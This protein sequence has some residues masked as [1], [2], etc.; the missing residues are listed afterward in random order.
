[1][2][3]RFKGFYL[4][5]FIL[6]GLLLISGCTPKQE[7]EN[8]ENQANEAS[9]AVEE[10]G[11]KVLRVA[12][13]ADAT[14]LDPHFNS[15]ASDLSITQPIFNGL[16]RFKPGSVSSDEIEGDL[17]ESWESNAEGT[18]WTFKLR[19]GVQ[20]HKGYGELTSEDVKWTFERILDP[21]IGSRFNSE[22]A[23]IYKVEAPAKYT[24]V[25]HLKH[26]DSAFLQR[27]LIDGS[28]GA[29]VKK[30]AIEEAG[31]N[32]ITLPV[33]TGP[34]MLEEYK[35]GQGVT[36]TKNPDYFRGEPKIDKIE[37]ITMS[38]RNAVDV[39]LEK[40]EIHL[41]VGETD[42]LWRQQ[43]E[44]KQ[45]LTIDI[46]GQNVYWGLF[47]NTSMKPLDDINVRK[48]IAHAIDVKKY[49]KEVYGDGGAGIEA[50][51]PIGSTL[52]GASDLGTYEYDPELSKKLLAEAGYENGLTLPKQFLSSRPNYVQMMTFIQEELR[53]ANID[54]PLEKVDV[55]TYGANIRQNLNGIVLYGRATKP[56]A[57]FALDDHYYGPSTVG[58]ETGKLNFS[59]YNKS[60]ALIEQAAKEI[61]PDKAV[62]LYK[63]IQQNIY[64][65]YVVVPVSETK[66]ILVRSNKVKLGYEIKGTL[67]YF[68]TLNENTAL[69]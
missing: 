16:V 64:D 55:A 11:E 59:H 31:T 53:K 39:A 32:S 15:T 52:F 24:V 63:E 25:I 49:V 66:N 26:P 7:V 10:S 19:E 68:Y 56:H 42:Q 14:R 8:S 50:I 48:A 29:I 20:W 1:M 58:K 27:I 22:L 36:L 34:F 6:L 33:G 5:I 12:L 46:A 38:D 37:Y 18:I 45:N 43:A 23:V 3:S 40:G 44:R 41:A 35:Q 61:D 69:Q 13:N 60:D 4:G 9:D 2:K 28:A 65:E 62:S 30:E 54:M 51:G 67:N 57:S 17:A 47:L 21:S